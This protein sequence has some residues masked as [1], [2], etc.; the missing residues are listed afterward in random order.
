MK[1]GGAHR[2][3][4]VASVSVAILLAAIVTWLVNRLPTT[5]CGAELPPDVNLH[6][7]RP[8]EVVVAPWRGRHHVYGIFTVPERFE[9]DQ[10]SSLSLTI[11]GFPVEFSVESHEDEDHDTGIPEPR[12]YL[13]RVYVPTR[14]ALWFLGT[15]RFGDLRSPC[16][17]WLV[18]VDRAQ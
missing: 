1:R 14:T 13:K 15:G 4:G 16:H 12:Y 11:R 9:Q 6:T 8:T 2:V 5:N 10:L 18:F 7:I 3:M 17:W